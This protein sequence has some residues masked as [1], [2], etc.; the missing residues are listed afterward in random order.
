M[1]HGRNNVSGVL[2]ADGACSLTRTTC[3]L[4]IPCYIPDTTPLSELSEKVLKPAIQQQLRAMQSK[5]V[6]AGQ[7]QCWTA[8]QVV[9]LLL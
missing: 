9:L 6:H 4:S 2:R 3:N 5:L 8:F 1:K 7:V